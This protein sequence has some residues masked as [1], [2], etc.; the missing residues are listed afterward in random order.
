MEDD[1]CFVNK[2]SVE[3]SSTVKTRPT[4]QDRKRFQISL[5]KE[6]SKILQ[7]KQHKL[8]FLQFGQ[9]QI[10][11]WYISPFPQD[12]AS[13][14]K[15]YMCQYCLNYMS[16][17]LTYLN[18]LDNCTIRHPPGNEIY[19]DG[20]LSIFEVHGSKSK[21]YCQNLCLLAKL[22]LDTKALY[23]DVDPF[24]FYILTEYNGPDPN[25]SIHLES[26]IDNNNFALPGGNNIGCNFIGYFSKEM[27]S[28]TFNLS[29]ICILPIYQNKGYGQ[30]LID[31]SYLLTKLENKQGSPEKPLSFSGC[32]SYRSYWKLRIA[33]KLN[34]IGNGPISIPSIASELGMTVD[35]VVFILYHNNLLAKLP[36]NEY[37]LTLNK[38]WL[39]DVVRK[40]LRR[41]RINR[42]YLQWEIPKIHVP[43]LNHESHSLARNDEFDVEKS[44]KEA[45]RQESNEDEI[46]ELIQ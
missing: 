9:F 29:C 1:F 36:N 38:E 24:T 44:E 45:E 7:S 34:T 35:D 21:L 42:D 3:E 46:I 4:E 41:K 31:F 5:R 10:K 28:K 30:Y 19:R 22:F 8:D 37:S 20:K 13:L 16:N 23:Y 39:A 32:I 17:E 25:A 11:T 27:D 15:L 12:F 18:H 40:G 43:T 33:E 26:P 2:L 6:N 14:K